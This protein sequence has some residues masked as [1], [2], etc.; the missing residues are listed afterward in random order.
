MVNIWFSRRSHQVM[1]F[2]LIVMVISLGYL[3]IIFVA[4]CSSIPDYVVIVV[5][6]LFLYQRSRIVGFGCNSYRNCATISLP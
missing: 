4:R 3:A 2:T 1:S 6:N 5:Q